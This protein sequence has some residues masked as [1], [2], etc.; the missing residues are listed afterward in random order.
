M[1]N[2]KWLIFRHAMTWLFL[3]MPLQILGYILLAIYIPF[4][5]T[6]RRVHDC[7]D[8]RLPYLLRWFDN[9]D[10]RD[11]RFGLNGDPAHQARHKNLFIRRYTWLAVRNPVNYFQRKIIGSAN[12]WLL[13]FHRVTHAKY[14]S[15][16]AESKELTPV[17]DYIGHS[18]GWRIVEA[19]RYD[20]KMLWEY[21]LVKHYGNGK[22]LRVRLGYKLGH[23]PSDQKS[24][25]IQWVF[26]INPWKTYRG[27]RK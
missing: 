15:P 23:D 4:T 7:P 26:S 9:A 14:K 24:G 6:D 19:Y 17:G 13:E 12:P 20:Y 25:S 27:I 8:Q 5:L 10:I 18:E 21:Y 11:Q 22:C 1:K 2:L 3:K 16:L